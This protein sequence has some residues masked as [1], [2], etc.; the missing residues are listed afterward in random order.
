[1]AKGGGISGLAVA[2]ATV[3]GFFVYI[4]VRNV[5]V[6]QG[7]REILKG[8]T[9]TARPKKTTPLPDE[10]RPSR[11]EQADDGSIFQ[12]VPGSGSGWGAPS[13]GGGGGGNAAIAEYG[14]R[15]IG[16]PY[17]WGGHAPGGFDCSGLVT[18]VLVHHMG[19]RNLPSQNHTVT[20]Q[21]LAWSGAKTIPR[22]QMQPGDL[23]CW[24][25]HM[26]IAVSATEMVHAPDVGQKVKISPIWWVPA[27][28]IRRVQ[29]TGGGS[30]RNQAI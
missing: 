11:F 25:G 30:G 7:L 5:P 23:V 4:G 13:S 17:L 29:L 20:T 14:Q 3:G 22:A 1:M 19:L 26:G 24:F 15:Y 27:P 10:L 16:T 21:F 28:Q 2:M 8:K 6:L 12:D 9:P 18:Y